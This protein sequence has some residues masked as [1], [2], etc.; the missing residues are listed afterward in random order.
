MASTENNKHTKGQK[1]ISQRTKTYYEPSILTIKCKTT[2]NKGLFHF[3]CHGYKSITLCFVDFGHFL[4]DWVS[5]TLLPYSRNFRQWSTLMM[6]LAN[7]ENL[8]TQ[9]YI[10]Y[11]H[12]DEMTMVKICQYLRQLNANKINKALLWSLGMCESH[13][14]PFRGHTEDFLHFSIKK[15]KQYMQIAFKLN[16]IWFLLLRT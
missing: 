14:L 5:T 15:R 4:V 16:C 10:S 12:V 2:V 11:K 8:S 6:S 3:C 9:L 1:T 13:S 7:Q